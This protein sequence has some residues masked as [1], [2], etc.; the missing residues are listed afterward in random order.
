MEPMY[1]FD[2]SVEFQRTIRR[3]IPE[4]ITLY[5]HHTFGQDQAFINKV[6]NVLIPGAT[7]F[8]EK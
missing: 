2:E 6:T 7:R 5:Q 4:D 1:A 3:Y 8:S